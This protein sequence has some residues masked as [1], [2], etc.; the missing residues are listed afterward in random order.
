MASPPA[1][2]SP[3]SSPR[4]LEGRQCLVQGRLADAHRVLAS[5]R[6]H[7]PDAPLTHLLAAQLAWRENHIRDATAHALEAARTDS[8]D[9]ETLC[10]VIAVLL[11][12]GE[13]VAA[14]N[15]LSHPALA[16]CGDPLLLMRMAG[17]RKR[18]EQH[19]EALDLLERA[20]ASGH[21]SPALSFRRGEELMFNGLVDE[22]E[23]AFADS[24]ARAPAHGHVAVPLVR[25]R[26]QTPGHNHLELLQRSLRAV[27]PGAANH[28]AIEFARYKTFEDLGRDREAWDALA[29]GNAMMYARLREDADQ[30]GSGLDRFIEQCLQGLARSRAT[31]VE[32]PHPIFVI[33]MPR[34]GSTLL[35]RMLGN[36]PDVAMAGELPDLGS[37]LHWA[38]DSRNTRADVLLERLPD[39]DFA[40]V[41]RRYLAQTRWRA[42]G[43]RFFV[44]K[45]LPNWALAAVIHA[46]LPNAPIL[47]LVRDPMDVCFSNWRMF[48]GDASAYSYDQ[49]TL[50]RYCLDYRRTVARWHA[51]MPG[52]IL[53]VP[54]AGLVREPEATLR[55]VLDFCGLPWE[56]G[57]LDNTGNRAPVS[58]LSTVQVRQPIHT[59]GFGQWQRYADGLV[60]LQ[61]AL[62][63]ERPG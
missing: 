57:C 63:V 24:L 61:E 16:A 33:G 46:A 12:T 9:P 20:R 42:H 15:L 23:A 50:A 18:L 38:A 45:Y 47:N 36:H 60:P 54:Y 30:R 58:T 17:H 14:R 37:Q 51:A 41:G 13:I 10:T 21:D 22:A 32:G 44:D 59:R 6:V 34:S 62:G 39:V 28:A 43:R 1:P 8:T 29:R 53:D 2:A 11:V 52:A 35:E 5:M 56:P 25:L 7:E 40:E 31:A 55:K 27:K 19:A 4:W 3:S 26:K 48:F 49:A